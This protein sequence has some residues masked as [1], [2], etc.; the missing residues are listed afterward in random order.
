MFPA[1]DTF[2]VFFIIITFVY[3]I[4]YT[5][6]IVYV[7]LPHL[8]VCVCGEWHVHMMA[9]G[10][11]S[12]GQLVEVSSLPSLHLGRRGIKPRSSGLLSG[13]IHWVILLAE[14]CSILW[15]FIMNIY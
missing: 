10:W 8:F 7:F 14:V 6:F 13:A 2:K 15:L 5:L 12:R 3:L 4:I 1:N 9:H 11:S